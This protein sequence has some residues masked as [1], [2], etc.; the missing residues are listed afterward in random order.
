MKCGNGLGKA[1]EVD[2]PSDVQDMHEFLRV[3]VELP[4]NRR[5]QTQIA[6][7]VKGKPG[8]FKT[9]KLKYERVPY[10][11]AHC[12]FMGHRKDACE[13]RRRG[14]PSLDYEAYE[15]RCSPFKK[16]ESRAHFVP[17]AGQAPARRGLS[18]SSFGSAESRKSAWPPRSRG[19]SFDGHQQ[20]AHQGQEDDDLADM[21]P[22]EDIVPRTH[23]Q[24]VEVGVH[25]GFDDGEKVSLE[26]VEQNLLCK[27]DA[28]QMEGTVSLHG[29][30]DGLRNQHAPYV[31]FLD[32]DANPAGPEH[33]RQATYVIEPN[34]FQRIQQEHEGR[35][36]SST[37]QL[38][39][40]SSDM[41]PAMRGLSNLQVSF[42][43]ALDVQMANADTVLGKRSAGEEEEVQGERLDLSLGLNYR[44]DALEGQ[45]QKRGRKQ[46]GAQGQTMKLASNATG[47]TKKMMPTGHVTSAKQAKPNVWLRREK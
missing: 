1:V 7:G 41:I 31:Q 28:M 26:V 40:R 13:K 23:G 21:P 46:M 29:Q 34:L 17:P 43:S 16:F 11:C 47:C 27:V 45:Q 37:G 38:G 22:L 6:V 32:D 10:Y 24:A 8:V 39:P 19:Q 14:V 9:Y 18:F 4:Y 44:D 3:R 35:Q 36:A 12:G 5:L 25:D 42:G 15:I 30:A 33:G 20:R 2:V